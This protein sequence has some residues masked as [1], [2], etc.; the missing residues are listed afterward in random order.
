MPSNQ[1]RIK[2]QAKFTYSPVGKACE[3]QI[4]AIEDQGIKQVEVLKSLK[5]EENKQDMKS[6]EVIFLKFMR[7][8]ELKNKINEIKK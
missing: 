2:E 4:K 8:K 7:T 6:I 5:S 3:K 1:N